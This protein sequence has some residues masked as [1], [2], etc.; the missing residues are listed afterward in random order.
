MKQ[1]AY[2]EDTITIYEYEDALELI[3]EL[4][5]TYAGD[6]TPVSSGGRMRNTIEYYN[7]PCSFDIETTT[8]K[9]GQLDYPYSPDKPPIAFPYLFQWCIYD[10]V[11]MCR[12]Y[13]EAMQIFGWITEYFRLAKNR[14]LV[15]FVHNLSYEHAFFSDLWNVDYE[16]CFAIDEHHPVTIVTNDGWLFRDSYKMTN[17]SLETLTKD[18]SA[19][20]K[21]NK[22]IMDYS[23]LRTPYTELDDNTL[24]YS[25]LD[26]LS[27]SDA[28]LHFLEARNERIW[29]RCPT[30]TSVI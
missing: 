8:I 14:R 30:S 29:T 10:K 11:I 9:P 4:S 26:V 25:A 24:I 28:I 12:R 2:Q 16:K 27:L 7:F 18:W 15:C 23:Q 17:M 13:P 20:W 21:K 6:L 3:Q 5:N 1:L 19:H 22:E